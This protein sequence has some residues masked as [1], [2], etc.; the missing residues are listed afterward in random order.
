MHEAVTKPQVL[1]RVRHGGMDDGWVS[2]HEGDVPAAVLRAEL[3]QRG[4][5]KDWR[6]EES[7]LRFGLV[8]YLIT[9]RGLDERLE[10]SAR[11]TALL[12]VLDQLFGRGPGRLF[13]SL[14]FNEVTTIW[15]R[16]G[17]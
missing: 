10:S 17:A 15:Q 5:V 7:P 8:R 14:G 1:R 4:T 13:P 2:P 9:N 3:E 12:D 6:G 16:P 11:V